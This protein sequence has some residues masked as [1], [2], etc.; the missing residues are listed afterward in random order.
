MNRNKIEKKMMKRMP[1]IMDTP[2]E[3]TLLFVPLITR[4]TCFVAAG[5][6]KEP[7]PFAVKCE[8]TIVHPLRRAMLFI[9]L[10][11]VLTIK[12]RKTTM[13]RSMNIERYVEEFGS[14][15]FP[16]EKFTR[17]IENSKP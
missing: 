17:S 5:I 14:I 1:A 6:Q 4:C 8:S 15:E 12:K 13:K 11:I 16:I 2:V 7:R 3:T 9:R 10:K